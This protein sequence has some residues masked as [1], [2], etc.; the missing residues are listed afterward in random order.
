MAVVHKR[1]GKL[2]ICIDPQ[3]LNAALKREHY[4]LPVLDDVLPKL[5]DA[6]VFSKLDVRE[7]YWHVR[8]DDSSSRL[9]TMIT[10]FGRYMWKRLPF[11]LK[12]SSE[13]FQ[14]K[15]DEAL[16]NLKGVFN[17]VDDII[18]VGCGST[19][20]E[21]EKDNQLNL[22]ATLE[23]C[24]ERN[25]TLN[26]EKQQTGL[27]EIIFHG[28]KITSEGVKVDEAKVDA[29]RDM[30]APTD[31]EGVRRL[32]GMAQYMS[33]FIPDLA[34]TLEPIR[35][36]TRKDVPFVWS[37]ECENA[38]NTLKKNLSESACLAYY[39]SSKELVIQADSCKH[40]I[41]AVLLQ[42]GRP[43][44][45]ASRALTPSERNWAQIEKEALAVLYGL[46]RF[47]QYTYGR[48][49]TIENDHKPLASI[50]RKPLSLAPKRLQDIMMRYNRYD[51]NFVFTKGSKLYL[52]DTLSRAHRD[53]SE[54]SQDER[55]RIM[56]INTFD[57]IPDAQLEEIRHATAL[58]STMREVI[59]L[60]MEGWPEEKRSV[61]PCVLPYFDIRDCLTVVDNI[62][63][64][65]EAIVIPLKMRTS[66]KKRL[67]SSHLGSESMLRR[68][69]NS[70]FWP[71][72]AS[73]IKQMADACETC[74]EMKPKNVQEPLKQHVDGDEPWQKIGVDIF[75]IADKHY[76]VAVDYYSNFIEVDLLTTL[77]S[78]NTI[79]LL[80]KHFSRYGIPRMVV[81]DGGPQFSSQEF[82]AFTKTWGVTHVTS[83]PMHQ[84]A[85]GKAES[86]VKIMKNLLIKTHKEG[87]DPY[88][89]MLEQRNT[90]R[91]DTGRSPAEMMF[92]R[93]T[94][95]FVP[96]I[97]S[98]PKD[99][100]I[101][102]KR[103]RRKDS[104]KRCHDRKSRKL[105]E[106]D[107]GQAVFFQHVEG[108]DWKWGKIT[109]ILGPST[110]Q[111]K[112]PDGGTYRRNRVHV[113]PTIVQHRTHNMSP[114]PVAHFTEE[115]SENSQQG[116]PAPNI[117]P[118]IGIEEDALATPRIVNLDNPPTDAGNLA[119]GTETIDRPRRSIKLP[120]RFKDF[121]VK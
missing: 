20:V 92:N 57:E 45:Y 47:D 37:E 85:N 70:V 1:D 16:G 89:A 86:A 14:R 53:C 72:M 4:R 24:A 74:Q 3:P 50:L 68:A 109:Q 105:S 71:R 23:R 33:R 62:L 79:H 96:T 101:R 49:I 114:N 95:S 113:R 87:G 42:D 90:P 78:A 2:R 75:Q 112:G 40:G 13:I 30:P 76:L 38:F 116:T 21:A 106:L 39:D 108:Q 5:K 61:S 104:V 91:Q 10:P 69:R 46:E 43:I 11:G 110:Y 44:E 88:E 27:K 97:S 34:G 63:L 82:Y 80:K 99:E 58:D 81:S 115:S 55:A 103:E 18:V 22:S 60:V 29:I 52:A 19:D 94:R 51:V 59:R 77:T 121:V 111:V 64:K 120:G 32:C 118:N 17:I 15:I 9:T 65:G 107:I 28:H 93:M 66:I 25:I 56:N 12:V 67:H 8:L 83:S 31:V 41:G 117:S 98:K 102:K 54:G 7:A 48:P 36:L 6:K 73:D 35:A 100:V 119:H 26:A 84:R